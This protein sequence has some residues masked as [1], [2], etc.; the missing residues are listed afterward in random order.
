MN[1]IDIYV[2]MYIY[3]AG[4]QLTQLPKISCLF[5][6]L[7]IFEHFLNFIFIFTLIIKKIIKQ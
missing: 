2:Y 7:A 1:K 3:S 4:R 5:N 6:L